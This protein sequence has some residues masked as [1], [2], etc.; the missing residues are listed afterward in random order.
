LVYY[1]IFAAKVK[2]IIKRTSTK[3]LSFDHK[4]TTFV[5]IKEQLGRE[6]LDDFTKR[7]IKF[8]KSS[9]EKQLKK[10]KQIQIRKIAD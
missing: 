8:T 6:I 7:Y 9:K 2:L 4:S 1:I 10:V 5:L 3:L